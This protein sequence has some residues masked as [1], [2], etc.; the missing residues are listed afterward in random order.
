MVE[1]PATPEQRVEAGYKVWMAQQ[2]TKRYSTNDMCAI[3]QSLVRACTE[4]ISQPFAQIPHV[5]SRR[6]VTMGFRPCEHAAPVAEAAV[7]ALE[8]FA[9]KVLR[10]SVA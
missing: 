9:T 4:R 5:D 2:L 10:E 3:G 1:V 8:R 6:T 7:A